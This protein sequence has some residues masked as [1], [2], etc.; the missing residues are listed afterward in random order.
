MYGTPWQC[1]T[2]VVT[3]AAAAKVFGRK[4]IATRGIMQPEIII[5]NENDAST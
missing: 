5:F 2:S 3:A 1:Y 4:G